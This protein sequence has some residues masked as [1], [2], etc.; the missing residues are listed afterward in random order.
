MSLDRQLQDAVLAEFAW[1]PSLT[2]AHIG[3]MANNG[4]ITLT[5]HVGTYMEKRAAEKAAA[6]VKGVKAVVEELKVKLHS[7]M[8]RSDE[9]IARA[10]V[11]RLS[12]E[13]NIP[14]D[15]IKVKVE[16]GFVTLSGTVSWHFQQQAAE[17]AVRGMFGVLG[18]FNEAIIKPRPDAL[19]IGNSIDRALHRAWFDP[20]TITVTAHDGRVKLT[21]SVKSPSD[22]NIAGATAWGAPGAT[23]VVN[24]LVVV[25]SI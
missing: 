25:H 4:I 14:K 8:V 1:E 20:K 9:D 7:S 18:V 19:N 11:D 16:D 10:A 12:W 24:D 22:R 15:S 3:V 2:P 5:G 17:R 21:G 6:R 13:V 23:S